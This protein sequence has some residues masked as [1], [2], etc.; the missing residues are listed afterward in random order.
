MI[1]KS[2]NPLYFLCFPHFTMSVL[3]AVRQSLSSFAGLGGKYAFYVFSFFR[4]GRQTVL[5][6]FI[7][8]M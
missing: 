1:Q 5:V 7:L 8:F 2:G 3:E 6:L 4:H